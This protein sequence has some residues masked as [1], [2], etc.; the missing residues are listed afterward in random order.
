M[1]PTER[2]EKLVALAKALN[3]MPLP[4]VGP[5]AAERI[6]GLASEVTVYRQ[7]DQ[8]RQLAAQAAKLRERAE[9]L[10]AA[11]KEVEEAFGADANADYMSP[12][13]GESERPI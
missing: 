7:P 12:P 10:A 5:K 9:A 8:G 3:D 2:K 1:T 11:C 13:E 4:E 6:V